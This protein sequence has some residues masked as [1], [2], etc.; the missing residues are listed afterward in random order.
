MNLP[1]YKLKTGEK[2]MTF[3]FVSEGRKGEIPKMITFTEMLP[4]VYNLGFGDKNVETG[5]MDDFAISNNGDTEKVLATVV[6]AVYT[7]TKDNPEIIV[8]AT[9]ST[10]ARNRLYR[11]GI[12]KHYDDAIK[13]FDIYGL[14][15]GE[16]VNFE[17]NVDYTAFLAKRNRV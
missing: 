15:D 7:F 3:D 8:H 16:W 12:S 9:G 2:V 13:D 17:K 14:R 5:E 4:L 1:V 10:N 6:S 11:I